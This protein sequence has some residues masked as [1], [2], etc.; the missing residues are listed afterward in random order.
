MVSVWAFT[1]V[2]TIAT[3]A[4]TA[5]NMRRTDVKIVPRSEETFR[6]LSEF[7]LELVMTKNRSVLFCFSVKEGQ[8]LFFIFLPP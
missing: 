6:E 7:N 2:G 5:H 4:I 8:L 1:C 3:A